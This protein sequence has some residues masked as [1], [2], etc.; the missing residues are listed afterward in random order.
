M[1]GGSRRSLALSDKFGNGGGSSCTASLPTGISI[2][3]I[4]SSAAT[5]SWSAVTGATY[6]VRYRKVGTASWTTSAVSAT[7][8]SLSGLTASSQYEVQVRSKCSSG[9][10]NYSVSKTFT[11][12][13]ATISYCASKGNSVSDEY[14]QNVKL[15]SINKTSTGGNGYSDFT[16]VSTNLSKGESNIITVNSKMDKH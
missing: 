6:D 3:S 7:T 12:S 11:T 2:G 1:S 8:K 10:S 13:S 4:T 15:G 9:N 16:S 14:I 5:V